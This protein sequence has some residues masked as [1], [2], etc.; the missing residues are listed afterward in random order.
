MITLNEVQK[1]I[2]LQ[3]EGDGSALRYVAREL[4]AENRHAAE[5]VES[6]RKAVH[7]ADKDHRHACMNLGNSAQVATAVRLEHLRYAF[8][9]VTGTAVSGATFNALLG[10]E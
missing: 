4:M 7:A 3:L 6:L 9:L 5:G 2:D 10:K 8:A 1:A